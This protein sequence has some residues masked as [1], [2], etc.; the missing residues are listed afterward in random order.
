MQTL[1]AFR[2]LGAMLTFT[3]AFKNMLLVARVPGVF[4]SGVFDRSL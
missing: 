2:S 4:P 3:L 1:A